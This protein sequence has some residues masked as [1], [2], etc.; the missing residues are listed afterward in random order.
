MTTHD[1]NR[2]GVDVVQDT[3]R[4]GFR[5]P[6]VAIKTFFPKESCMHGVS[7]PMRIQQKFQPL[8]LVLDEP[9]EIIIKKQVQFKYNVATLLL[10]RCSP[11][12]PAV[13]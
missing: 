13:R 7:Y 12:S 8:S 2:N 3:V 6:K 11:H 5:F 9:Y 1:R 4:V 10:G